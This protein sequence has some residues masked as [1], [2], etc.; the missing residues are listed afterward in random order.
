M[1]IGD[2]ESTIPFCECPTCRLVMRKVQE[3]IDGI[4]SEGRAGVVTVRVSF[5][6]Y[7]PGPE[8]TLY[9]AGGTNVSPEKRMPII[10]VGQAE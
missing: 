10:H 1:A 5:S 8:W 9:S 2:P 4:G 6:A 7:K 3:A